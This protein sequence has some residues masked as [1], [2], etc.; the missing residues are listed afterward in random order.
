MLPHPL[1]FAIMRRA[2]GWKTRPL[3]FRDTTLAP[4]TS[5]QARS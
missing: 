5:V 4:N 3:D 1:Y 2:T